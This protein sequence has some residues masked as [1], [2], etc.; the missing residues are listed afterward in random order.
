MANNETPMVI[1]IDAPA[2]IP[3]VVRSSSEFKGV[4]RMAMPVMVEKLGLKEEEVRKEAAYCIQ[5]MEKSEQLQQVAGKSLYD[6]MINIASTGLTL[7]PALKL[8]YL[9]PRKNKGRWDACLQPSYMG[10]I[11]LCT[12]PGGVLS[13]S[14]GIVYEGDEYQVEPASMSL[15]ITRALAL[16][17]RSKLSTAEKRLLEA[18]DKDFWNQIIFGYSRAV[19]HNGA[20]EFDLIDRERLRKI[21]DTYVK[22]YRDDAWQR[23]H[24]DEW[25][26]K[27]CI[28]HHAKTLPKSEKA[29]LAVELYHRSMTGGQDLMADGTS[30]RSIDAALSGDQ[31]KTRE[32]DLDGPCPVCEQITEGGFCRNSACPEAEPPVDYPEAGEKIHE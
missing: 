31:G 30:A 25:V 4:V 20:V 11:K 21:M 13:I 26:K 9:V 2:N 24:P 23:R 16:Q 6:A 5:I 10:M 27:T 7:N 18:R 19:L 29:A 12:D 32:V 14:A 15:S 22:T 3:A 8:A 17:P 1:D 28:T